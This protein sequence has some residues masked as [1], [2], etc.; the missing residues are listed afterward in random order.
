MRT[1]IDLTDVQRQLVDD[2][3][4]THVPRMEVWAFGSRVRWTSNTASDLDLVV[5]ASPDQTHRLARLREAFDES[6][7]PF[8]VDLHAWD[9]LPESFHDNIARDYLVLRSPSNDDLDSANVTMQVGDFMPFS[10]GRSL[11]SAN[12]NPDGQIPVYGSN[13]VIGYHDTA[14]T[15]GPTII[16]GRKGTVGAV[17]YSSKPCWPIDTTFYVEGI[18][19]ELVRFKYYMLKSLGLKAM[20]SDSAVPGLNRGNA[21]A[22]ELSVPPRTTQRSVSHILGSLDDKIDLSHQMSRTL[23]EM[24]KALFRS[25][26][27]DFD[28]VRAAELAPHVPD[29]VIDLFPRRLINSPIGSIPQGWRVGRLGEIAFEVKKVVQHDVVEQYTPFIGLEHM[30]R[31]SIILSDWSTAK[32]V[33][34]SKLLFKREQILFGKLRPYFHKVGVAPVSGVCSTDIVVVSPKT[35]DWFGFVLGH[36]SSRQF[37]DFADANCTGTRMP[38]TNWRS[39]ADYMVAIPGVGVAQAFNN[40]ISFITTLIVRMVHMSRDLSTVRD[41]L[42]P[43]LISGRLAIR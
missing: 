12:R 43:T 14:L 15:K 5:F 25:W 11:P 37:V 39:M 27:V 42:L 36:M 4:S 17:H 1:T 13:G 19:P 41:L 40:M 16:V 24:A 34:S 32:H 35:S 26:F 31:H 10:Y 30:P 7:L 23:E 28:P 21:H 29:Y 6:G 8:R 18:D 33:S 20:N 9:D 2:L 3:L 22:Q 38:R